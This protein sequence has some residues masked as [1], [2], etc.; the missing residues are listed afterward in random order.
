MLTLTFK[1]H[2]VAPTFRFSEDIIDFGK[3]SYKFTERRTVYLTNTSEVDIN[4]VIRVPGDGRTLQ[5]EFQIKND[6][7]RLEADKTAE[8]VID[9]TPCMQQHYDNVLVVD[10]EGV[11]Q[12]MLAIPIKANCVVP[13]V[14]V[15]PTDLIDYGKCFLKHAKVMQIQIINEDSLRAKFEIVAQDEQSKRIAAY[16]PDIQSG[17]IQPHSTQV[18]NLSLRTEIL[19][20]LN[21]QVY[22]K[23]D[24][25]HIPV[26]L[27]IYA[28]STGPIVELDRKE[29][30]FLSKPVLETWKESIRITNTSEIEAEYTA[31]TKQKESIWKV[32]QRHDVLQPGETKT[33]D[34]LCIADEVQKFNDTL[35]IIVSNGRDEEVPLR[36]RGTG[37][38]LFCQ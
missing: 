20:K 3:I 7:G 12:D 21:V 10:L 2:V 16:E 27:T 31:F 30:D 33:I 18:V 9:F 38:T 22:I 11:G 5:N 13:K 14:R 32:V 26:M 37:S 36:I 24:G 34:V 1:G 17:V 4:Y 6:R 19:N 8:I 15:N 29:L 25:H 28:D 35:H 23:L